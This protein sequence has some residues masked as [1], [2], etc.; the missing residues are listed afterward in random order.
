VFNGFCRLCFHLRAALLYW[1]SRSFTA[2]LKKKNVSYFKLL[3]NL[4]TYI[5]YNENI[6]SFNVLHKP[7]IRIDVIFFLYAG[8]FTAV[9]SATLLE[10]AGRSH[11]VGGFSYEDNSYMATLQF[12]RLPYNRYVIH[13]SAS[14][15]VACCKEATKH[16]LQ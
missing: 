10:V 5:T 6:A 11:T 7:F 14:S 3:I 13:G 1:F 2:N 12:F 16:N 15:N 8:N 4:R 9:Q